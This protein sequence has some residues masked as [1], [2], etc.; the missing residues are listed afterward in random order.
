MDSWI[1]LVASA[2]KYFKFVMEVVGDQ[3][4]QTI[5]LFCK[6]PL[7]TILNFNLSRLPSYWILDL[8]TSMHIV[9]GSPYFLSSIRK[10]WLL[11]IFFIPLRVAFNQG[12]LIF[13]NSFVTSVKFLG[14][15]M[16]WETS[17]PDSPKAVNSCEMSFTNILNTFCKPFPVLRVA[18]NAPFHSDCLCL[19]ISRTL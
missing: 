18:F 19:I 7:T 12:F 16:K 14:S 4:S 5:S 3:V 1:C 2:K 9:T 17:E 8:N 13:S 11:I 15:G 10:V 6:Y